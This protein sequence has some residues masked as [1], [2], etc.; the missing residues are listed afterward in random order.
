MDLD[1]IERDRDRAE[2]TARESETGPVRGR[3]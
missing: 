1:E 2:E 3:G